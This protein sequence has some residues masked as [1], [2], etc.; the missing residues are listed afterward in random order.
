MS[1]NK[2]IS[3]FN[4]QIC[5]YGSSKKEGLDGG[6][7]KISKKFGILKFLVFSR[8]TV[9]EIESQSRLTIYPINTL[10]RSHVVANV[11]RKYISTPIPTDVA[12]I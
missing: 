1:V 4:R 7:L 2:D 9:T 8:L 12:V 11:T 3:D 10:K 6:G 5:R